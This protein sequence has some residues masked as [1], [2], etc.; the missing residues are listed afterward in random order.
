MRRTPQTTNEMNKAVI[1]LLCTTALLCGAVSPSPERISSQVALKR[2]KTKVEPEYPM[3]ARNFGVFGVVEIDVFIAAD[4]SVDD[5]KRVSGHPVLANAATKAA[6]K[7]VFEPIGPAVT[8][9]SVK[10]EQ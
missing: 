8:L 6:K 5:A 2:I 4:G 7:W 9:V 1:G 10:F 3:M